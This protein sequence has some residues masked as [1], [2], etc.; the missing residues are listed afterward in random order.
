MVSSETLGLWRA[1]LTPAA[2]KAVSIERAACQL[3]DNL[4]SGGILAIAGVRSGSGVRVRRGGDVGEMVRDV[5]LGLVGD[6]GVVESS[7]EAGSARAH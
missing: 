3:L 2:L 1:A 7:L 4:H 6:I 5:L